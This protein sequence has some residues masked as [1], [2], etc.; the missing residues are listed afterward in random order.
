[1]GVEQGKGMRPK[2]M[3]LERTARAVLDVTLIDNRPGF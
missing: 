3:V 2:Q 1:M